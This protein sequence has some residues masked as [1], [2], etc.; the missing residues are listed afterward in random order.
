L[1]RRFEKGL[2]EKLKQRSAGGENQ[3]G[4]NT[5]AVGGPA[6][7]VLP[8]VSQLPGGRAATVSGREMGQNTSN[9]LAE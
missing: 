2:G 5:W 8:E 6:A 1:L 7:G 3:D 9:S 4:G